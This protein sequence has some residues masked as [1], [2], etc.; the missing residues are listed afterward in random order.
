M[1]GFEG[2]GS[3]DGSESWKK[4]RKDVSPLKKRDST[5]TK[6]GRFLLKD[7]GKQE[8]KRNSPNSFLNAMI[9]HLYF[10]S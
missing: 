9:N 1:D 7:D 6:K 3:G 4:K 10:N 5:S 2:F 8:L